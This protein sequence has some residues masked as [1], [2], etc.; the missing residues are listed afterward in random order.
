MLEFRD[1]L[2]STQ[3]PENKKKY[4]DF[5]RRN[6]HSL[7]NRSNEEELARGPYLFEFRKE[8]LK[9]L[10]LIQKE[11]QK[12]GPMKSLELITRDEMLQIRRLW[13]TEQQDW[14]DSVASIHKEVFGKEILESKDD[15]ALFSGDDFK[16]LDQISKEE[17][18]DPL[19]VARLLGKEKEKDLLSRRSKIFTD[20]ENIFEEVWESE[21][22]VLKSMKDR[23]HRKDTLLG[24][25]FA[26]ESEVEAL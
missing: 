2:S 26:T 25:K 5:K 23:K 21:A 16:L 22:E 14:A 11:V 7:I 4:R 1:L 10:L 24:L 8:L 18:V 19:L 9:K 17:G 6:G 3:T 13:M 15:S 12:N 20:L